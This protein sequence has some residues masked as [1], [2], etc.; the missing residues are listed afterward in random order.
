MMGVL[1]ILTLYI[2]NELHPL[3]NWVMYL[4]WS[5]AA[6]DLIRRI[7]AIILS[8]KLRLAQKRHHD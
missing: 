2:L 7:A 3:D 1:V 6:I 5:L 4:V 8:T